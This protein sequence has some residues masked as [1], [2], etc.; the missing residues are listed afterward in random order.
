M[1]KNMIVAIEDRRYYERDSHFDT[2]G[3]ARAIYRGPLGGRTEGASTIQQEIRRNLCFGGLLTKTCDKEEILTGY[4]NRA[5]Y[6]NGAIGMEAAALTC[7]RRHL[8]EL[9]DFEM[10]TLVAMLKSPGHFD[11]DRHPEK[12]RDRATLFST[13]WSK[14]DG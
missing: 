6:R 10:A 8:S 9:N 14:R 12:S 11:P 13:S 4:I 3:I 7:F 1:L 5:P 2:L